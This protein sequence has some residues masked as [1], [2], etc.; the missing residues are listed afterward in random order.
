TRDQ[1][2]NKIPDAGE[3][4]VWKQQQFRSRQSACADAGDGSPTCSCGK[5]DVI[6]RAASYEHPFRA[7]GKTFFD[8]THDSG[9]VECLE[10]IAP[11]TG[12]RE[13]FGK[14]VGTWG[15]NLPCAT[16]R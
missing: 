7:F 1:Y 10:A 2:G 9:I 3:L 12:L 5:R 14:R 11:G 15:G 13:D 4:Q 16:V 6:T 8:V